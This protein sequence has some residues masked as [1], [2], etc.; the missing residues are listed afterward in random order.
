MFGMDFFDLVFLCRHSQENYASNSIRLSR[1]GSVCEEEIGN[2]G[3][4]IHT[5]VQAI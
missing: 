3:I 4:Y 1:I 2:K 5:D